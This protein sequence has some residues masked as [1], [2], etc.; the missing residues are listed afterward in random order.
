MQTLIDFEE[1]VLR[2]ILNDLRKNNPE[3][4]ACDIIFGKYSAYVDSC[5]KESLASRAAWFSSERL[6]PAVLNL[7]RE[8]SMKFHKGALFYD[9]GLAHL[10]AGNED[11]FECLHAMADQE[12]VRKTGGAH[13]RGTLNLR[14]S[15]LAA[16]TITRRMQFACDLL[17]G[18]IAGHPANF[19]FLTGTEPITAARFDVWRQRL[20]ALHQFEL[21]RIVRDVEV[22]VGVGNPDYPEVADHPFV[23][24]RLAKALSHLAQWVE[25]CLT[26]WQGAIEYK[27]KRGKPKRAMSLKEKLENDVKF[28]DLR[29]KAVGG[30]ANFLANCPK[31]VVAIDKE[32]SK[33]LVELPA[34]AAVPTGIERTQRHCRLLRILNIVRNSTAHTIEEGLRI[35]K[36]ES[37][38]VTLLQAVFVSVFVICQLEGKPID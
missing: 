21:L 10:F 18:K 19:E 30:C 2:E 14:S 16:Q 12:E 20:P 29:N 3:P 6:I 13:K 32:L 8:L 1:R 11:G 25:S 35:Y 9:T 24:L 5:R 15:G 17:N 34:V 7:E 28:I 36:E 31:D 4:G 38:V 37:Q 22:F 33:L 27:T 26:R 23:M